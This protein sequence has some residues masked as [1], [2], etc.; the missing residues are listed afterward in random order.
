MADIIEI[1]QCLL[2][3]NDCYKQ[4]RKIKPVGIV[5]HSTGANNPNLKRY[6]QP[7][8]GILGLNQN[9]NSWN[10]GGVQK[11]VHAFIGKDKNGVVRIYQTLP[12]DYRSWGCGKGKKGTYNDTHIHFEICE[13]SLKDEKYFNEAFNLAIELCVYLIKEYN[14]PIS[15]VVSHNEAHKLGYASNHG[16]CNHWLKKF[17]KNMDWFRNEISSRNVIPSKKPSNSSPTSSIKY[18]YNGLDYSLVFDP[19]YYSNTYSDLKKAFGSNANALWNHF[20]TYGM[21]EARIGKSNF[22]VNIYKNRY[23]DLQKA[24]GDNLPKYYQHY[25]QFG[26]KE[27]RSAV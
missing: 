1:N 9:N 23:V 19:I 24:F 2:T 3:N 25:C 16:D 26:F 15:N 22:N 14:I 5:V 18:I 20:K 7:D 21:K 10:R 13:D 12:W 27:G 6:I 4:G 8:D 17:N 11:C